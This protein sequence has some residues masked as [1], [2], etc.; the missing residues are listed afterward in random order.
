MQRFWKYTG[1]GLFV[2]ALLLPLTRMGGPVTSGLGGVALAAPSQGE[3]TVGTRKIVEIA[4]QA[5]PAVVNVSSRFRF[6]PAAGPQGPD[7]RQPWQPWPQWPAPFDRFRPPA[8]RFQPPMPGPDFPGP[9][10]GG[11]GSGFIISP[12]GLVL[13]NHHVVA[14][15]DQIVVTVDRGQ[16]EKEYPARLIGADPKTDI[17][18]IRIERESGSTEPFPYLKLG[19]SADLEVGEWVVAIGNPFGLSHTVTTGII[20]AKGRSMGG[21]YD[22][23]LQTDASINPGNSGGPLLNMRGEVVGMNT[24]I[25][26]RSGGNVG[27]GFAIPSDLVAEIVEQLK[28]DGKVTRGWLGVMI[29]RLTPELARAYG[30]DKPEGALVKDVSARGPADKAGVQ[31]GDV[32]IKFE[33]R[34][35]SSIDE[36][37]RLV[38]S[39]PPGKQVTLEVLRDGEHKTLQVTLEEMSEPKRA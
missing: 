26:S 36:L 9:D 31:R 2:A 8:E 29:Q 23:Y 1:I 5:N 19:K 24:A 34:K 3:S 28:Q 13:T 27:I 37:P 4:K 35:I 12:D 21:P 33:N 17:A 20:S 16:G 10:Q 14:R 25:I 22:D 6:A 32:I 39:T 11:S 15:A 38:A 18:L 30:L 7:H